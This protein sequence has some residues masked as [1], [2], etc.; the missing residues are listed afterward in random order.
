M[1]GA[2]DVRFVLN[3][4]RAITNGL[5][6]ILAASGNGVY[7]RDGGGVRKLSIAPVAGFSRGNGKPYR[8]G[9]VL[10]QHGRLEKDAREAAASIGADV[11][12]IDLDKVGTNPLDW[13]V[14]APEGL[15]GQHV[16]LIHSTEN[17]RDFAELWMMIVALR[18]AGVASIAFINIHEGYSRQDKVFKPGEGISAVTMLKMI[19]RFVDY[20]L[21]LNIHYGDTSG[22]IELGGYQVYNLNAF[23][24]VAEKLSDIVAEERGKENL[25]AEL[26]AHPLLLI[27][28]DDGS[29]GYIG[30]AAG[31]LEKYIGEKYGVQTKVHC[32]YM[33]KHRVSSTEVRITGRVLGADGKPLQDLDNLRDCWVRTW[34]R[35]SPGKT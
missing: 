30:E 8:V 29:Y 2:K 10:Y 11:E 17:N 13:T 22:L 7:Y 33:D 27:S 31:V 9:R 6:A 15:K 25:A 28:P 4:Y 21:G 32:G 34:S 5:D 16:V 1:Y 12:R 3:R 23:V 26:A 35:F 18:K 19:D 24:Q 14:A 20:H